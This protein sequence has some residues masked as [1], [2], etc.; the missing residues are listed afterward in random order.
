MMLPLRILS[1]TTM[2]NFKRRKPKRYSKIYRGGV[3]GPG[4][5]YCG[6]NWLYK[7]KKKKKEMMEYETKIDVDVDIHS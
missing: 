3:D 2:T 5:N 7:T 4:C 6:S 1:I